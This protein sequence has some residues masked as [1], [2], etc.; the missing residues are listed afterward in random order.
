MAGK[1]AVRGAR[2][3]PIKR[4]RFLMNTVPYLEVATLSQREDSDPT[5]PL[6]TIA[7]RR[8]PV[9]RLSLPFP[10][11]TLSLSLSLSLSYSL[12]LVSNHRPS[13]PFSVS[14]LPSSWLTCGGVPEVDCGIHHV[15]GLAQL[16]QVKPRRDTHYRLHSAPPPSPPYPCT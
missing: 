13:T 7:Q 14:R 3:K 12:P 16:P 2:A 10:S 4:S 15:D 11:L 5:R 1:G 8:T 6:Y 9:W